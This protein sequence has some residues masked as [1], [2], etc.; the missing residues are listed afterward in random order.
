MQEEEALS[1]VVLHL[2]RNAVLHN[3][4]NEKQ[5]ATRNYLAYAFNAGHSLCTVFISR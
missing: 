1:L 2:A 4:P 3:Y 5:W